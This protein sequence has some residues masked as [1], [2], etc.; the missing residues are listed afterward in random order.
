M[1]A[2]VRYNSSFRD[3]LYAATAK[4]MDD[5]GDAVVERAKSLIDEPGSGEMYPHRFKRASSAPGDPPVSQSGRLS[6]SI[7]ASAPSFSADGIE[8]RVG[9]SLFYGRL[10]EVG[11]SSMAPRPF[12]TPAIASLREYAPDFPE[13][14]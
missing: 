8:V 14:S 3:R 9:T 5:C 6:D 13:L 4:W 1:S 7:S 12:L 2:L 10:L 11:T